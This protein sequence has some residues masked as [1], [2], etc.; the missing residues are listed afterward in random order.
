[1]FGS[2]TSSYMEYATL[3]LTWRYEYLEC[4]ENLLRELGKGLSQST[5]EPD[6]IRPSSM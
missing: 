4:R 6:W 1:M 3:G 5:Y 2:N